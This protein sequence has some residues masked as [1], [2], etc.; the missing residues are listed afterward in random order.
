[1]C[2][3]Q[4]LVKGTSTILCFAIT[5]T[6]SESNGTGAH[7]IHSQGETESLD[8]FSLTSNASTRRHPPRLRQIGS[9]DMM[10][11]MHKQ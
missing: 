4:R 9:Q 2:M 7:A 1:M 6:D 8:A 10:K 5:V 3:T 11:A